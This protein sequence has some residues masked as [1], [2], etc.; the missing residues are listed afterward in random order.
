MSVPSNLKY[1]ESH[2]WLRRE[3]DGTLTVGITD[4]AQAELGDLVYVELPEAGRQVEAREA[5]CVVESTKAASD[6]YA[7]VTGEIVAGNEALTDRPELVNEQPF[8]DGWLFRIKPD[9]LADFDE[10]LSADDYQ[11]ALKD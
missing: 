4:H 5:C 1:T 6:V 3:E 11:Q 9:N 2:E 7:P 8:E 10:L